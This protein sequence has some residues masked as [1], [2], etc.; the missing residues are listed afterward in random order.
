MHYIEYMAHHGTISRQAWQ[1]WPFTLYYFLLA[2]TSDGAPILHQWRVAVHPNMYV[3]CFTS[4]QFFPVVFRFRTAINTFHVIRF[5]TNFLKIAVGP[6]WHSLHEQVLTV[7]HFD[8][9]ENFKDRQLN[10][11]GDVTILRWQWEILLNDLSFCLKS[12]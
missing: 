12:V 7:E 8:R 1:A 5:V 9:E 2:D 3:W 11:P 10:T 6:C 4:F